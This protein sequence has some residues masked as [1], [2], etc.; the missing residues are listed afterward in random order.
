MAKTSRQ[1]FRTLERRQKVANLYVQGW[2]QA[3]IA[4][5]L[6]V[7]QATVC[8][9]LKAI[10]E[11][12][13]R[14]AVRNFDMQCNL[15]L[16]K[17]DRVERESWA[18][19]ERSQKPSQQARVKG[20]GNEQA[21]DRV[22]KNQVGD[23]RFLELVN[24]CIAARRALLGLDAVPR[25]EPPQPVTLLTPEER[26]QHILAILREVERRKQ[27]SE[28]VDEPRRIETEASGTE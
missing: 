19:W 10:Q 6:R 23:P 3:S 2:P 25:V 7:A 15:E 1:T 13:R 26:R 27:N 24:K 22:I 9:D 14:S 11:E 12:W 16:Q 20:G 5:E 4:Q 8:R 17:I 18:A 21:A 28:A